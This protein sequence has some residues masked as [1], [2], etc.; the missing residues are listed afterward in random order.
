M[1]SNAPEFRTPHLD[2]LNALLRNQRLPTVDI[3]ID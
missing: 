3:V 1:T 2:K